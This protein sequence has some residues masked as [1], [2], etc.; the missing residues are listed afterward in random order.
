MQKQAKPITLPSQGPASIEKALELF[1]QAQ[2]M[3]RPSPEALDA[4][5]LT[6]DSFDAT[7]GRIARKTNPEDV[8]FNFRRMVPDVT[9]SSTLGAVLGALG[10]GVLGRVGASGKHTVDD[11][12]LGAVMGG[13]AG[14]VGGGLYAKKRRTD[15]INTVNL[16]KDYGMLSPQKFHRIRPLLNYNFD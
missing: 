15:M 16:L 3:V 9:R 6:R 5:G 11:I 7:L 10:G 8:R 12:L 2:L 13:T 1:L 4:R 14:G